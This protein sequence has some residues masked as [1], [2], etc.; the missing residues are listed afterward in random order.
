MTPPVSFT[1]LTNLT[2]N[3]EEMKSQN[4]ELVRILK[5]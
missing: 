4:E 3:I 2:F 5:N 1:N